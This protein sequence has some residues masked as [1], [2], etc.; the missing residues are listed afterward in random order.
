M[1]KL[2]ALLL[3]IVMILGVTGVAT[4]SNITAEEVENTGAG[5]S[6][7]HVVALKKTLK[8]ID[9]KTGIVLYAPEITYQYTLNTAALTAEELG[10]NTV[11]G[12]DGA[13]NEAYKTDAKS[14]SEAGITVKDGATA[15][16]KPTV[17]IADPGTISFSNEDTVAAD[18]N[19]GND[20]DNLIVKSLG[21]TT[22]AGSVPGI[23]RF[24]ITESIASGSK[25]KAVAGVTE[26]DSYTEDR[27]LDVYVTYNEAGTDLEVS[28]VVL[29]RYDSEEKTTIKTEGW[30]SSN[31]LDTYETVDVTVTKNITGNLADKNHEFPFS[32]NVTDPAT[33]SLYSYMDDNHAIVAGAAFGQAVNVSYGDAVALANGKSFVIYGV[34]KN[35]DT[36]S[37]VTVSEKNDTLDNYTCTTDGFDSD[38]DEVLVTSNTASSEVKKA[39][40]A[41]DAASLKFTNNLENISPTGVVLRI[42]PYVLILAAGIALLL[43]SRKRKDKE[44]EN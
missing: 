26:S 19:T 6:A 10:Y 21:I 37:T 13:L 23:Y 43:I 18:K 25:T 1:K 22:A 41:A 40:I 33:G 29:F 2:V 15:D 44:E 35:S 12:D 17:T 4:A 3:S 24:K 38:L 30:T 5:A 42:A 8:L 14:I 32:F 20:G 16:G 9:T 34:P 28:N 36:K 31:D 39:G 27:F 7:A 11:A